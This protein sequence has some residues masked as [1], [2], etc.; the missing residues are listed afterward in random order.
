MSFKLAASAMKK[1]PVFQPKRKAQQKTAAGKRSNE[2]KLSPT[3]LSADKNAHNTP[4][5]V[6]ITKENMRDSDTKRSPWLEDYLCL[7]TMSMK[8]ITES[9][10][11]MLA[12]EV[13]DWAHNS[14]M[15]LK[16][17]L[18]PRSKKI[19]TQTW[20]EWVG[21]YPKLRAAHIEALRCIG[22]RREIGVINREL[23]GTMIKDSM[24][25]YDDAWKEMAEWKNK[26][27]IDK[28]KAV[29]EVADGKPMTAVFPAFDKPLIDEVV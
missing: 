20:Y 18:F 9:T 21:K 27:A 6:D 1:T 12:K 28:A 15:A 23:D 24:Y 16:I 22:D 7:H 10:I 17:T 19:P 4:K 13:V 26:M 5:N 25:M 14:D 2:F 29:A 11:D 8:P 3:K